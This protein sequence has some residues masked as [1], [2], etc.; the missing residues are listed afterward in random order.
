M[1]SIHI[2]LVHAEL[3]TFTYGE[4]HADSRQPIRAGWNCDVG[5][6]HRGIREAVVEILSENCVAIVREA[7]LVKTLS[8]CRGDFGKLLLR[9]RVTAFHPYPCHASLWTLLDLDL[10]RQQRRIAMIFW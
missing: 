6:V 2:N 3:L 9:K 8:F 4:C 5:N 10:N 1:Q 7:R